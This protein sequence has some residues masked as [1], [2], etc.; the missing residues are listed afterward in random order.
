MPYTQLVGI[1]RSVNR[2]K[3]GGPRYFI[4]CALGHARA[5]ARPRPDNPQGFVPSY[6]F[7]QP[8]AQ[9]YRQPPRHLQ[10]VAGRLLF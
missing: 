6:R 3:A 9:G 8:S 4:H 10:K 5:T 2:K 1:L 7:R